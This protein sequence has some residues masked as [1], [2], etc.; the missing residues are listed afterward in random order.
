MDEIGRKVS[1]RIADQN[2]SEVF[3]KS[4]EVRAARGKRSRHVR[5]TN[6]APD[7]AATNRDLEALVSAGSFPIG[8]L[9]FAECFFRSKFR[10]FAGTRQG[11]F[12]SGGATSRTQSLPGGIEQDEL[13]RSSAP[14]NGPICDQPCGPPYSLNGRGKILAPPLRT[15]FQNVNPRSAP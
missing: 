4:R 9:S 14:G 13:R 10:Y 15:Q 8:S 6:C 2:C 5:G 1:L 7:L 11:I 12:R 3:G